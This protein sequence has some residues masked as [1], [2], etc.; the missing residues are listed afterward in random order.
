MTFLQLVKCVFYEQNVIKITQNCTDGDQG[1]QTNSIIECVLHC[2][3]N[4]C[5]DALRDQNGRCYCVDKEDCR[6]DDS[7]NHEE[8]T[9]YSSKLV[10]C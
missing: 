10:Y 7:E 5:M 1:I 9:V 8:A 4:K 2:G 3:A 6:A